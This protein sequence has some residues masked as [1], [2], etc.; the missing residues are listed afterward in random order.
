ARRSGASPAGAG[1]GGP[2]RPLA[3]LFG[4]ATAWLRGLLQRRRE[5]GSFAAKP[6]AG[7]PPRQLAPEQRFRLVA[8][9][10][11]DPDATWA[12]LHAHLGARVHLTTVHRA[13]ARYGLTGKKSPAR[14]RARPP[15]RPAAPL[16]V[17]DP[18]RRGGPP[19][20]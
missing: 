17:V 13:L 12:Q 4:A 9:V 6:H 16:G 19:S 2:R 5:T 7:G 15:G 1:G 20:L 14:Q 11:E 10:A 3:A 18:G 8:L